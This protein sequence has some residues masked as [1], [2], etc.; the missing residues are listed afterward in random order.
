M[1]K[2]RG[3]PADSLIFDLEDAVAPDKKA[4]ARVQIL[5]A[6]AEGDYGAREVLVR[7]NA[8]DTPWAREDIGVM[9]T[10]GADGIVLPKVNAAAEV[11][12]LA[13]LL[14]SAGAP[15]SMGLW[16]MAET[17]RGILDIDAIAGADARLRGILL[18]TADLAR[19]TRIRHTPMRTGFLSSLSRCVLAA[20]AHALEVIDGV[21]TALDDDEGL[22]RECEQ[23]RDLGFDGK[24]LVHPSQLAVANRIF[25]PDAV[26]LARAQRLI[27]GWRENEASGSAV[28]VVDGRMVEKLHVE[29]AERQIALAAAIAAMGW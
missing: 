21:Y 12:E 19:E 24:S 28:C 26:E 27:A 8:L 15:S 5:A 29:Q 18:G 6:L 7:V 14:Q 11:R 23:A 17:A 25:S 16:I 4:E 3:L 10:S 1:E 22:L 13:A 20:R 9:A 2:A